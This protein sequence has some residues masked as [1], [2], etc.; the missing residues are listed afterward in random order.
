M[1]NMQIFGLSC[2]IEIVILSLII[3]IILGAHLLCSCS[4]ITISGASS[5]IKSILGS[6]GAPLKEGFIN[7]LGSSDYGAALNY[8]MD[9][10][11]PN[12]DWTAAATNYAKVMGNTDNTKSGQYYKGTQVPLPPGQL[13]I[14][15]DNEVKPECCP[16]YYSSSTGCVCT[17][18]AQWD[19]LNE[20]GGNRTFTTEY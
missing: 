6:T 2:R 3:G 16:S 18:Q 14:F 12:G 17:S 19:Y 7:N 9:Q 1:Y 10:G 15:A 8:S 20:R 13:F 4:K 5:D 11:V